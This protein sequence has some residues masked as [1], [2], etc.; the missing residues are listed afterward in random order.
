MAEYPNG[1]PSWVELN[2]S[3]PSAA[4]E[5][6]RQLFGWEIAEPDRAAQRVGGYQMFEQDGNA[7]AGLMQ[8][9]APDGS[10]AWLTYFAVD[11]AD[12]TATKVAAAGGQ[13][14]V[15]PMNVM[16][17][18]RM[19]AFADPSGAA[20]GVW[21]AGTFSGAGLV[22]VAGS[23]CWTEVLTR[24][25]PAVLGFYPAVF[26]WNP[27]DREP[28]SD[29]DY[30]VWELDGQEVGG[31]M[32]MTAEGFPAGMPSHWS[33]C[34]AVEDCDATVARAT[35]LGAKVPSA[36]IDLPMGRLAAFVDPLGATFTVM[37]GK[38]AEA[39]A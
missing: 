38:R 33:V 12:E 30:T 19:A 25:K 3:D 24:D 2:A 28:D 4:G 27:V 17:I 26:D 21:Q 16:D 31:A 6:Y 15:E 9:M 8:S 1:T 7:V 23:L 32:A 35:E 18:G 20:F 22:N 39:R 37:A 5:F 34:F 14:Y 11:D 10:S 36:P 29:D 13:T